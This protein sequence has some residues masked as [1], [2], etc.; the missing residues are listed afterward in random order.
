[1]SDQDTQEDFID[2]R[3]RKH[4]HKGVTYSIKA[5]DPYGF[6]TITVP[7]KQTPRALSGLFTSVDEAEKAIVRYANT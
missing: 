7:K 6:W 4:S 1:M 3:N 5:S 2:P